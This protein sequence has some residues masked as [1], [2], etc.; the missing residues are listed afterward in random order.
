MQSD[1]TE[2]CIVGIRQSVDEF[3]EGIATRDVVVDTGS[4]DEFVVEEVGEEWVWE[5]AEELFEDAGDAVDVVKEVFLS[6]EVDGG[7]I[8]STPSKSA[9]STSE[10]IH[11]FYNEFPTIVKDLSYPFNMLLLSRKPV[12]PLNIKPVQIYS[13]NTLENQDRHDRLVAGQKRL[14]RLSE[15]R[16]HPGMV[17]III[18][19]PRILSLHGHILG[20]LLWN[21]SRSLY[22]CSKSL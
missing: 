3:V 15:H 13:L 1:C 10:S 20:W 16:P 8:C 18:I 21:H 14:Q 2:S 19:R 11:K 6:T 22:D 17:H 5:V 9:T 4:T 12:Y 7:G